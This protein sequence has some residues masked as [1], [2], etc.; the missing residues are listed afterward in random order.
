MNRYLWTVV[1]VVVLLLPVAGCSKGGECDT[2]SS[3]S[4]CQDG[5]VCTNFLDEDGN[6]AGQRCG[7]GVGATTC[8]VR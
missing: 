2:C 8:R 3:D 5:F 4:D 7:S 6:V 1:L